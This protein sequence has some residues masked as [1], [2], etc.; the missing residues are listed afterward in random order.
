MT[1]TLTDPISF[2]L[3]QVLDEFEEQLEDYGKLGLQVQG[4][5][6]SSVVS[7]ED[8]GCTALRAG[9]EQWSRS[10]E[11]PN[12]RVFLSFISDLETTG[13]LFRSGMRRESSE[14]PAT[15]AW[16]T[17]YS[18]SAEVSPECRE[19]ADSA[20]INDVLETCLTKAR[21][22]FSKVTGLYAELDQFQDDDP[23]DDG[24]VVIRVEVESDQDTALREYDRWVDW[25]TGYLSPESSNRFTLTIK[26]IQSGAE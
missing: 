25:I 14:L 23:E 2:R 8:V 17:D 9:H 16:R 13:A 19:F 21:K 15:V 24:H 26:R 1:D 12:P 4:R 10:P 20:G 5:P 18:F 6:T 11:Q 7:E 22:V 3:S